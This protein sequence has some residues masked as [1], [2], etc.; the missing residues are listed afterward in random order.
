[1]IFL[2]WLGIIF[3]IIQSALFSGL[4]LA[5]FTI[6]KLRLNIE[7]AQGN[8]YAIRIIDLREDSNFLLTTIL[9]GNVSINV[10]LTLLSKS[11]M[12]GVIAFF[13][14]TFFITFLGE[15]IPQAYFSRH[16]L[17]MAYYLSPIIRFYQ[18]LLFPIA[19]PTSIFLDKWLK[20]ERV[21]YFYEDD[22]EELIKIHIRNKESDIDHFEGKG[23][24]NFLSMDEL[25]LSEE[26]EYIDPKSIINMKFENKL[27]V[28][29]SILFSPSDEFL[30]KI[31]LSEKKWVIIV[32][33]FGEP[34]MALNADRFL[35]GAFFKKDPF[36]PILY[37]H[38]PIIIKNDYATLG[39]IIPKFKVNPE[40]ADDDVIDEDIIL[41]WGKEKKV[42]TGADI[43]GRLLRGIVENKTR[44]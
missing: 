5:F 18:I 6:S 21:Q 19:K 7:A 17:K 16:A 38:R 30:K 26:G 1:M 20:R 23:A 4:N 34:K 43:L 37:C 12:T 39:E 44:Q 24:L 42:I 31:E 2:I 41:Y 14:S 11:V 22:L 15:I 36:N 13:F 3:C 32:D 29:P 33:E 8:E 35:R 28:F 9:W 25:T 10:L 40:R 27:P